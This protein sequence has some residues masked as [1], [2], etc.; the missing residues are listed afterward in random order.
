[1]TVMGGSE[2][3][4]VKMP[5]DM[6]TDSLARCVMS[7][8]LILDSMGLSSYAADMAVAGVKRCCVDT[9]T[10]Q[11][12]AADHPD[13]LALMELS[14]QLHHFT[15][16]LYAGLLNPEASL[17]EDWLGCSISNNIMDIFQSWEL[18][19]DSSTDAISPIPISILEVIV[20]HIRPMSEGPFCLFQ[21]STCD[22]L[23]DRL[24]GSLQ[25][26]LVNYDS[27]AIS[28]CLRKSL[29]KRKAQGVD[30]ILE[31]LIDQSI[32]KTSAPTEASTAV[33]ESL[34]EDSFERAIVSSLG[35]IVKRSKGCLKGL[36]TVLDVAV[37][38]VPTLRRNQRCIR[39]PMRLA[40]LVVTACCSFNNTYTSASVSSS[41][42]D[43]QRESLPLMWLLIETT[44]AS[45]EAFDIDGMNRES[46]V[47]TFQLDA[48]Q[49]ALAVCEV[50]QCYLKSPPLF[51]LLADQDDSNLR[52]C[53]NGSIRQA[54]RTYIRDLL[55]G[56]SFLIANMG[57]NSSEVVTE[58]DSDRSPLASISA[59][60]VL[61]NTVTMGQALILRLTFEHGLKQDVISR[62]KSS[63]N[64]SSTSSWAVAAGDVEHLFTYFTARSAP[65]PWV[66][67]AFLQCMMHFKGLDKDFETVLAAILNTEKKSSSGKSGT[68]EKSDEGSGTGGLG[69]ILKNF[70]LQAVDME[71]IVL[72]RA[73]EIFNSVPSCS[74]NDLQEAE[75]LL[76]L[77]PQQSSSSTVATGVR[78]ERNLM[79]VVRLLS[80]MQVDLLPLQLRLLKPADI[81]SKLL[82]QRPQAYYEVNGTGDFEDLY[83]IQ[84]R[85]DG[86][87]DGDGDNQDLL[88]RRMLLRDRSPPGARLVRVLSALHTE[89]PESCETATLLTVTSEIRLEL[90]FAAI[91]VED[92][93]GAYCLCRALL[94]A[95]ATA[96][97][98]DEVNYKSSLPPMVLQRISESALLV[99]GM[100]DCADAASSVL[101]KA[102][103]CD[104]LSLILA[105]TP[106]AELDRFSPLWKQHQSVSAASAS[107][108]TA[109]TTDRDADTEQDNSS[110]SVHISAAQIALLD[111]IAK[112]LRR[113]DSIDSH[114]TAFLL[115]AAE[116]VA[117]A[118]T[119]NSR[120][121]DVMGHLL[122]VK[123]HDKVHYLIEK[124]YAD[125]DKKLSATLMRERQGQSSTG[126]SGSS[127]LDD[128]LIDRVASKG[129]SRNSAKR[130]VLATRGIGF[131]EALAW[132]V[133][134][135]RD[136]D[137]EFPIAEAVKGAL[138]SENDKGGFSLNP[139]SVKGALK[140][141]ADVSEMYQLNC[142]AVAPPLAVKGITCIDEDA[143][144]DP[145]DADKLPTSDKQSVPEQAS[146]VALYD[147]EVNALIDVKTALETDAEEVIGIEVASEAEVE[148]ETEV[149]ID[150]EA[151][152]IEVGE[153]PI[154]T[155]EVEEPI[156]LKP[157]SASLSSI[158]HS[159]PPPP[160]NLPPPPSSLPPP[161]SHLPPP[162]VSRE[163]K[164]DVS[165]TA[166]LSSPPAPLSRLSLPDTATMTVTCPP[167][168]RVSSTS[169]FSVPKS[170]V[171]LLSIP[172]KQEDRL[173]Q[174]P[175]SAETPKDEVNSTIGVINSKI[176]QGD[177]TAS[178]DA[179]IAAE[180]DVLELKKLSN[181]NSDPDP[182]PFDDLSVSD[183][184]SVASDYQK[185]DKLNSE[186]SDTRAFSID[187][188]SISDKVIEEDL[189][190]SE[191]VHVE[192]TQE[193]PLTV[194]I[195]PPPVKE[196]AAI[197][198]APSVAASLLSPQVSVVGA[199][200]PSL[201]A[202]P[203][204]PPP[205]RP[206][207]RLS[208]I[209]DAEK[210]ATESESTVAVSPVSTVKPIETTSPRRSFLIPASSNTSANTSSNNTVMKAHLA[211]RLRNV[212]DVAEDFTGTGIH[213]ADLARS[214]AN[215]E[216]L[217]AFGGKEEEEIGGACDQ[218]FQACRSLATHRR[219][220]AYEFL[221]QLLVLLPASFL[222]DT[223]VRAERLIFQGITASDL[224]CSAS[225]SAAA[226][227]EG[228]ELERAT[229]ALAAL[230][231]VLYH[232]SADT[233]TYSVCTPVLYTA[234]STYKT[235]KLLMQLYK[236]LDG[237]NQGA[238]IGLKMMAAEHLTSTLA[239]D[240]TVYASCVT[241]AA[242]AIEGLPQASSSDGPSGHET[243]VASAL[244]T[245]TGSFKQL[246]DDVAV[247]RRVGR[248]PDSV[249]V[250]AKA[251]LG[252]P[253]GEMTHQ[254]TV[255]THYNINLQICT[256][257][258]ISSLLKPADGHV[259]K[260][261]CRENRI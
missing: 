28:E 258:H 104:L 183:V 118:G 230:R 156:L 103:R 238:L 221:P 132:A 31:K 182:D 39:S 209:K 53:D 113:N 4:D 1:M 260:H 35:E 175:A 240:S 96:T 129:F 244:S 172:G 86:D 114:P 11:T 228:K 40:S 123:D 153:K 180:N 48:I 75:H 148:A 222:T 176:E 205:T 191:Y 20:D 30:S 249:G 85:G 22:E 251:L 55:A 26:D 133:E 199:P 54:R 247:L 5:S 237:S 23:F 139:E 127:K 90:L 88:L 261:V 165:Q 91:S 159:F 198:S 257:V 193:L 241:D 194:I 29:L 97:G 147:T 144:E 74:S 37:A 71:R 192:H 45:L 213:T 141:I 254:L 102:L 136:E 181:Q 196:T 128:A 130:A 124:L 186:A 212:L 210:K 224:D 3:F 67:H 110:D 232:T 47:I 122:L 57:A 131:Q 202:I 185:K 52:R 149:E 21:S 173:V 220:A 119:D 189:S 62:S 120:L 80:D 155:I 190:S 138:L 207:T 211:S 65:P 145:S 7:R 100:L 66:G 93:E 197:L 203:P 16:A 218:V 234:P 95:S 92:M 46:A 134:H 105:S 248:I 242:R 36:Q 187:I 174:H 13:V 200:V 98:D 250:D 161:P 231:L 33:A 236:G 201:T 177:V 157:K 142:T 146:E 225:A 107:H 8:C 89:N 151:V 73:T 217:S 49:A 208:V 246:Q 188:P 99:V 10:D 227:E 140:V 206:V 12:S 168:I 255:P 239:A 167:V 126:R 44:P 56:C 24:L 25:E 125:L 256:K 17:V 76:A 253:S 235:V 111:T 84:A 78:L 121:A 137:F 158:L 79:E 58:D 27:K 170:P 184:E 135:S 34:L 178:L 63:A 226:E 229:W 195:A 6:S 117:S 87:G 109:S 166:T 59:V 160:S 204:P 50:V 38:S 162:P 19:R 61:S 108:S 82:K 115:S 60:E 83:R 81:A 223:A 69:L 70:G 179:V 150:V 219:T 32:R 18:I 68:A 245:V 15:G 243:A 2:F 171:R 252:L 43:S 106:A 163:L 14:V 51:L 259:Y 64:E 72:K 152:I 233:S 143:D 42:T 101:C 164:V 216:T 215:K 214:V 77:L 9:S 169:A 154:E 41:S 116:M 94:T 112:V